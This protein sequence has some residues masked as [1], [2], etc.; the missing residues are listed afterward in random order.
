MHFLKESGTDIRVVLS[1]L[2]LSR[3]PDKC[4]PAIYWHV[5]QYWPKVSFFMVS[6]YAD[7]SIRRVTRLDEM[8]LEE[9][10]SWTMLDPFAREWCDLDWLHRALF[11]CDPPEDS[12]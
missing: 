12:L 9:E 10:G 6:A 7:V 8:P 5:K 11:G 2:L 3:D 1:D 4:G